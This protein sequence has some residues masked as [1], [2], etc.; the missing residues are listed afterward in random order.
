MRIFSNQVWWSDRRLDDRRA[1]LLEKP[2]LVASHARWLDNKADLLRS[3]VLNQAMF[4]DFCDADAGLRA[5]KETHE[6]ALLLFFVEE[7]RG[8]GFEV[9][10][11]L[12]ARVQTYWNDLGGTK[13]RCP[14]LVDTMCDNGCDWARLTSVPDTFENSMES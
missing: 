5:L 1:L 10:E 3:H 6:T 11:D 4:A 12:H 9:D 2:D 8:H 7:S 14:M 13:F